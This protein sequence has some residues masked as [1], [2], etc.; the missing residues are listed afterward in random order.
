M[1]GPKFHVLIPTRERAEVLRWALKT[2]TTQNYDNLEI[3]VSDN[4]S[5]DNTEEVVREANDPRVR[6]VRTPRRVSMS[7]NW[8]FALSHASDGWVFILGDDDGLLPGA[9]EKLVSILGNDRSLAL[10]SALG[11]YVWPNEANQQRGRLHV[12]MSRG[13]EVRDSEQWLRKVLAGRAWYSEL[14]VLYCAGVVHTDLLAKAKRSNG[15]FYG[16]FMP[17]VYSAIVASKLTKS[18][19]YLHEPVTIGGHSRHSNSAAWAAT[20]RN[21]SK[22]WPSEQASLFHKEE[23]LPVHDAIPRPRN[24]VYPPLLDIFV[25]ESFLQ[26][27][28]IG[29]D[30]ISTTPADQFEVFLAKGL[31][32]TK[33][34]R[35]WATAFARRHDLLLPEARKKA[36]R[37]MPAIK[38]A[39]AAELLKEF[40][41]F[42]RV[43]PSFGLQI[44]NV[45]EATIVADTILKTRPTRLK[46]YYNTL[47]RRLART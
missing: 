43:E 13:V 45:Y 8:E 33:A 16:S 18:F 35:E 21:E 15:A 5:S 46:S 29:R 14:P 41:S 44:R 40:R 28:G 47:R 25:F 38:A 42:Y 6:Y 22:E 11:V 12:P 23:N 3:I 20:W 39:A 9:I 1:D 31:E 7:E 24:G 37:R 4:C 19:V 27:K 32:S 34:G 17:D 30:T 36:R 2:V 10:G 26:S